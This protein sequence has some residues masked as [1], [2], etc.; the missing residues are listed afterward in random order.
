MRHDHRFD[1]LATAP[2]FRGLRRREIDKL[3]SIST[4]IEM[5]A[6]AVLTRE[7]GAGSEAFIV[8]AG[9]A[10]VEAGGRVV[11]SVGPGDVVGEAALIEHAPRSATV[12]AVTPMR[13]LA[14]SR[15]EFASLDHLAPSVHEALVDL[16]RERARR[17]SE[18]AA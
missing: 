11:G 5:A 12:R 17:R 18:A 2:V 3:A 16:V 4:E 10:T 15:G 14:L 9:E 13:V 7:G 8:L 6:G 1:S